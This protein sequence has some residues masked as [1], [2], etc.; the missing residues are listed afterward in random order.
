M[1]ILVSL[2]GSIALVTCTTSDRGSSQSLACARQI[3]SERWPAAAAAAGWWGFALRYFYTTSRFLIASSIRLPPPPLAPRRGAYAPSLLPV[4]L[5]LVGSALTGGARY[6]HQH[7]RPAL[8][9]YRCGT[10]VQY[11]VWI[12]VPTRPTCLDRPDPPDRPPPQHDEAR[13]EMV[14]LP[15]L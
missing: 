14:H 6:M 15:P 12:L 10:A 2:V 9:G 4:A 1:G 8:I 3:C 7:T 13:K 11:L 5:V